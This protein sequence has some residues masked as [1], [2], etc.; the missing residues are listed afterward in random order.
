M[1]NMKGISMFSSAGIA[2]TIE[3]KSTQTKLSGI[4]AGRLQ[5]HRNKIRAKYT[6]IVAPYYKPSVETDIQGTVNVMITA[7]SLSNF[8]YQS[9]I[10]AKDQLLYEPLYNIIQASLGSDISPKVNEYVSTH[11]G[12]GKSC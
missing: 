5:L 2:E 8:L 7:N 12:I 4:N 1:L 9:A 10:H 3:A 11:F 6:I